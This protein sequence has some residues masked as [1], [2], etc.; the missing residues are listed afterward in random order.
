MTGDAIIAL[1]SLTV[2]EIILGIDNIIFISIITGKLPVVSQAKARNTGL[3]LAL[4][5]RIMLLLTIKCIVRLTTPIVNL[6]LRG[7]L[8]HFE[9]TVKDL[10]LVIDGTFLIAK[11]VY[12]IHKKLEGEDIIPDHIPQLQTFAATLGQ[13]VLIDIVFSFDSI[14]TAVGL[15]DQ[16]TVMTLAVIFA[17]IVMLIFSQ[18]ISDFINNRPTIKMLALAFLILI[19][20]MLVMEGMHQHVNK[21]YIYFAMTFALVIELFNDKLRGKSGA[22]I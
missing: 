14:L 4:A 11:S 6:P 12:E 16:I 17:M 7:D 9:P 1:I 13:I 19:G 18:K 22:P 2:I 8:P 5:F 3:L 10:I 20:L 15:S 21:G